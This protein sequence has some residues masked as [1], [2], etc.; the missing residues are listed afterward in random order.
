MQNGILKFLLLSI[1]LVYDGF[2]FLENVFL[3][4]E[5]SL[6]R[7]NC[8]VASDGGDRRDCE[9]ERFILTKEYTYIHPH[10]GGVVNFFMSSIQVKNSRN[11]WF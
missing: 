2:Y 5:I 8:S 4:H 6:D 3:K 10:K 1:T 11:V 9:M 7:A